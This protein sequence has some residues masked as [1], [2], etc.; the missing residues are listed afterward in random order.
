M[1]PFRA[2]FS[3]LS[4]YRRAVRG[5]IKGGRGGEAYATR[6]L[7]H[8]RKRRPRIIPTTRLGYYS[9]FTNGG[10]LKFH[11][12][13]INDATI[14]ANGTIAQA[15]VNIIAQGVTE[16]QRVGRKCTIRNINWRF[17]IRLPE[18]TASSTTSDTVRV[19]VYHD[20]QTNGAAAAVTDIL[21]TDDYQ[22][23]NNLS[24]KSRFRT[25]MDRTYDLNTDLSGDGTTVDS[26]RF[27]INDSFF[28]KCNISIE[29]DS[30]TGAITEQRSNN[31][32]VL[33]LS[34]NGLCTFDS[35][36]RVRYSDN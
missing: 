27:N 8:R 9:K 4:A 25:L 23:F 21:E 14:A 7:F 30:T 36:M 2:R 11:D 1:R 20:K 24:N 5:G 3:G 34:K 16:V 31:I 33:L 29:Y 10:E 6:W 19:M 28:K 18:G 32:G 17:N 35:K 15:S 13:D 26:P 12:L 22:S